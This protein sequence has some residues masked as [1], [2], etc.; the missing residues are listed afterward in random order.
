MDTFLIIC[1]V[2]RAESKVNLLFFRFS[3]CV[4][5]IPATRPNC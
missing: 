5:S 3:W 1:G 2:S 4:L